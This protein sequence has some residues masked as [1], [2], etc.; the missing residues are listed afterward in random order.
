VRVCVCMHLCAYLVA[1]MC[2]S[3]RARCY[4]G[5]RDPREVLQ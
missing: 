1:S 3:L 4:G 5:G 2:A